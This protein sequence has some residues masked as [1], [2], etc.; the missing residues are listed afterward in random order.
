MPQTARI[1]LLL[2]ACAG[3]RAD[4]D[5]DQPFEVAETIE[6]AV[7]V[8]STSPAHPCPARLGVKPW[9][10]GSVCT[11]NLSLTFAAGPVSLIYNSMD[12]ANAGPGGHGMRLGFR[13]RITPNA[14]GS[15]TRVMASGEPVVFTPDGQGGFRSPPETDDTMTRPTTD[16]YVLKVRGGTRMTYRNPNGSA[17]LLR[18]IADRLGNTTTIGVDA[19]NRETSVTDPVGNV[20]RLAWSQGRIASVTNAEG[21]IWTLDYTGGELTGIRHPAVNGTAPVET[22]AYDGGGRH[23]LLTH[24]SPEGV[25]VARFEYNADGSLAASL[26]PEGR[27]T[28]LTSTASQVRITDAFGSITTYNFTPAGELSETYDPSGVRMARNVYDSRHR[29][30]STF[31][32]LDKETRYTYDANDNVLSETDRYGKIT[33]WTYDSDHNPTSVIDPSGK[34]TRTTY[35][36]NGL[37]L[38]V[39][40]PVGR[41]NRYNRDARGNLLSLQASDGTVVAA[42]T[43]GT[44]GEW[45]TAADADGRI[46][47][48]TYDAFLNVASETTPDGVTTT[49]SS[50]RLGRPLSTTTQLGEARNWSYDSALR[51]SG[52]DLENGGNWTQTLDNDGRMVQMVNAVGA[53]ALTLAASWTNDGRLNTTSINGQGDQMGVC[54]AAVPTPPPTCGDGSGGSGCGSSDAGPGGGSGDGGTGGGSGCTGSGCQPAV[55]R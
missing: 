15:V 2:V 50:S 1:Y 55:L 40:D 38:V 3:C 14:D 23:L 41:T 18:T 11:G 51:F 26:D 6:A 13:D 36:A 32:W 43:Y 27:R 5:T 34:I 52:V 37:P 54:P 44:R 33:R 22:L 19:S 9:E 4:D 17:W 48:R 12:A 25:A 7:S 47:R 49:Y 10:G 8:G 42:Y 29:L 21:L 35:D 46:T 28:T 20:T 16:S 39:T 24:T 53:T 45:L 31:D 30:V